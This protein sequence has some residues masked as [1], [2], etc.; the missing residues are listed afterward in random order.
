MTPMAMLILWKTR[1][2][3]D[4]DLEEVNDNTNVI[5]DDTYGDD[6]LLD[7]IVM[8]DED[9]D[10]EEIN[11]DTNII[12]YEACDD[13]DLVAGNVMNNDGNDLE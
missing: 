12:E 7:D 13:G 9:D 10:L 6:Y 8:N 3:D 5:E 4:D 2:H 11:D 1:S